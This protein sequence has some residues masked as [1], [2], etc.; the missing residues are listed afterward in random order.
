MIMKPQSQSDFFG[1]GC[2]SSFPLAYIISS[3]L[4]QTLVLS[5]KLG[6]SAA[7]SF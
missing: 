6:F 3:I 7:S 4:P 1:I 5:I 2:M